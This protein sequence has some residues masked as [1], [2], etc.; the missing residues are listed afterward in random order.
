MFIVSNSWSYSPWSYRQNGWLENGPFPARGQSFPTANS[1][2]VVRC[3]GGTLTLTASGNKVVGI[4]YT[5]L[6]W[7]HVYPGSPK[8]KFCPLVGS[9]IILKT[10]HFRNPGHIQ[11]TVYIYIY[12]WQLVYAWR[13]MPVSK[14]QIIMLSKSRSPSKWLINGVSKH[15]LTGM[16]LQVLLVVWL[17]I[18]CIYHYFF[19]KTLY[20]LPLLAFFQNRQN[21]W[22]N[23]WSV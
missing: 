8:S 2:L 1:T 7:H 15:L 9:G 10:C 21:H 23:S 17:Y 20:M 14:W 6:T 11:Y 22:T 3:M 18:Y 13:I 12:L 19:L 16:I 4:I 5:L